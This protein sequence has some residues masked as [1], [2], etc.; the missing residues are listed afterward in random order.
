ML[1]S[2]KEYGI[3]IHFLMPTIY[4]VTRHIY[5]STVNDIVYLKVNSKNSENQSGGL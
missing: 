5:F 1:P 3:D 4:Y 2:Q